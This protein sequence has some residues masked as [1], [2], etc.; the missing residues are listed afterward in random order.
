MPHPGFTV[1][2]GAKTGAVT[3][4]QRFGSA[5]NL[6]IHFH[7]LCLDGA[8]SFDRERPRFHRAPRPTPAA[9]VRLLHTI[10]TRVARLLERQGLLVRDAESE[11]LDFEPG[12]ALDQLIGASIRYRIAIGPNAG[13]KA[14]TLR[15]VPA[16]PEPFASTLLAKSVPV[17]SPSPQHNTPTRT[18]N[19]SNPTQLE[20]IQ[21]GD[22]RRFRRKARLFFL[23][24]A[25]KRVTD[26]FIWPQVTGSDHCPVGI[27]LD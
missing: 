14:L 7:M 5:L 19:G 2:S 3:L 20:Q 15:T 25:H 21:L 27:D 16:Q 10:S 11:H 6:N 12:E 23:C 22:T 8:Y 18:R 13:R 17:S 9:L 1:A 24:T 4:I 26:A